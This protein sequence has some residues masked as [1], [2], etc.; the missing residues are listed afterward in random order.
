MSLFILNEEKMDDFHK[1]LNPVAMAKRQIPNGYKNTLEPLKKSIKPLKETEEEL[2]ED[3]HLRSK[4][5]SGQQ[6]KNDRM[7]I[8]FKKVNFLDMNSKDYYDFQKR[9]SSPRQYR[10]L[11]RND[12]KQIKLFKKK[13][14]SD[15]KF[16]LDNPNFN[17]RSFVKNRDV[18]TMKNAGAFYDPRNRLVSIN[19]SEAIYKDPL[20]RHKVLSHE[21]T[22][23][24][25]FDY[26]RSKEGKQGER[27]LANNYMSA[28]GKDFSFKNP[29]SVRKY[30]SNPL[31]YQAHKVGANID[32]VHDRPKFDPSISKLA[33]NKKKLKNTINSGKF[34]IDQDTFLKH[35]NINPNN[36]SQ[37]DFEDVLKKQSTPRFK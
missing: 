31:E 36:F 29:E 3:A 4:L 23:K 20:F 32:S 14:N 25:Q 19:K 27:R 5:I 6:N 34:Q 16:R 1:K 24:N 2:V 28:M 21:L 10:E 26:A 12:I 13:F 37:K 22:H 35:S 11:L 33:L 9:N 17:P 30:Y 18:E 8:N 7:K 15:K